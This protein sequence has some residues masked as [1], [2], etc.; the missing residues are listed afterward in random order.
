MT[1]STKLTDGSLIAV[2][3]INGIEVYNLECDK[4][5][6]VEDIMLDKIS[7]RVVYAVLSFG[8]ILGA[9]HNHCPLPWS[10]LKY[11]TQKCGYVI[12]LNKDLLKGAPSI[13][14]D[15]DFTSTLDYSG[16][17]HHY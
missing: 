14:S 7:G 13:C 9:D 1:Y 15:T 6:E 4:L 12:N 5:G 17:V 8:W 10:V 16:G 2:E 11:D 3:K